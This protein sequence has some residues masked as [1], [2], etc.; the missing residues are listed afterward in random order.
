[1]GV[2]MGLPMLEAMS[3]FRSWGAPASPAT[4]RP[5]VRLAA[6]YMPNG[7]NADAWTPQG[8]GRAFE[9][10]KTLAPLAPVKEDILV[11]SDLWNAASDTGDGH[12]VKTGAFLTGTTITRTTGSSLRSGNTS[13]D[14]LVAQ[15]IGNFTD[16]RS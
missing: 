15:R 16:G 8:L 4:V 3:S 14:Q 9:L 6:L 5:P 2:M 12:Y 13:I 11:F 1:M 7:V 10:S